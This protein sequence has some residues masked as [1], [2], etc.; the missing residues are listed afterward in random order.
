MIMIL[1]LCAGC[2]KS[3]DSAD[4]PKIDELFSSTE[5]SYDNTQY[6]T[7]EA[8]LNNND[9]TINDNSTFEADDTESDV[10]NT[11]N[12][13]Q[14]IYK[15]SEIVT[16]SYDI[17]YVR[18]FIGVENISDKCIILTDSKYSIYDMCKL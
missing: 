15:K 8:N 14:I 9:T 5:N 7:T 2:A 16:D 1:G 4:K 11:D 17:A 12:N 10:G 6:N 3:T 13:L 18:T